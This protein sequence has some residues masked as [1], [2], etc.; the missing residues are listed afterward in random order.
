MLYEYISSQNIVCTLAWL[1]IF[2]HL[3][4]SDF[5]KYEN[6]YCKFSNATENYSLPIAMSICRDDTECSMV[7]SLKCDDEGFDY[8]T[9][10]ESPEMIQNEESCTFRKKGTI[11]MLYIYLIFL[12]FYSQFMWVMSYYVLTMA[13]FI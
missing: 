9:C 12:P 3:D 10:Q 8:Q 2:D 7:S 4:G 1:I 13:L 5:V 11:I 6:F